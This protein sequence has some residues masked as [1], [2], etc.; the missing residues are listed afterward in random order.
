M[1]HESYKNFVSHRGTKKIAEI[2][3]SDNWTATFSFEKIA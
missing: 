2:S 3:C 1:T